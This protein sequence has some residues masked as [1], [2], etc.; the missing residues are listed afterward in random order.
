MSFL[1]SPKISRSDEGGFADNALHFILPVRPIPV[2]RENFSSSR[3]PNESSGVCASLAFNSASFASRRANS[4]EQLG[5][6]GYGG[7]F[8]VWVGGCAF[9]LSVTSSFKTL[10]RMVESRVRM[11]GM[12]SVDA[13]RSPG[14]GFF[15]RSKNSGIARSSSEPLYA[16]A[17]PPGLLAGFSLTKEDGGLGEPPSYG[18]ATCGPETLSST[19]SALATSASWSSSR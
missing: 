3:A 15:T 9:A 16:M 14:R 8:S 7:Y 6:R 1:C 2:C 17:L 10:A 11:V 13:E 5:A 19:G 12:Q 18:S 4:R